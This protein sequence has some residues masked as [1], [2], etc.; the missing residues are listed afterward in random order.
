VLAHVLFVGPVLAHFYFGMV[1]AHLKKTLVIFSHF[2][3]INFG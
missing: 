1:P 2:Y 3:F